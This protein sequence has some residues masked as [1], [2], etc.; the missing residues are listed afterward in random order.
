MPNLISSGNK[1]LKY[2]RLSDCRDTMFGDHS[3]KMSNNLQVKDDNNDTPYD[4][5]LK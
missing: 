1:S 3:C 2:V 5:I 4:H